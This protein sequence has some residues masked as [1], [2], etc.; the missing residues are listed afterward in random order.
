[1]PVTIGLGFKNFLTVLH[2]ILSFGE[3]ILEVKSDVRAGQFGHLINTRITGSYIT[4]LVNGT[5]DRD[6]CS[7]GDYTHD[8]TN[9]VLTICASSRNKIQPF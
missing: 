1:M 3:I 2:V 5:L 4:P 6:T 7:F 8:V 9:K